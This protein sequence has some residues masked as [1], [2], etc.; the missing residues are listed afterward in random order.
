MAETRV[1]F[2]RFDGGEF[3]HIGPDQAPDGTYTG[4]NIM[5]YRNGMLGPRPGLKAV[6][7]T[8][9]GT[10]VAMWASEGAVD[11]DV[12]WVLS[13][14]AVQKFNLGTGAVTACGSAGAPGTKT[15]QAVYAGLGV[16]Y[17]TIQ[18]VGTYKVDVAAGTTTAVAGVAGGIDIAIV[19]ER[20]FVTNDGTD[21]FT[22]W[23]SNAGDFNTFDAAN[24]FDVGAK[25]GVAGI[26]GQRDH[27]AIVLQDG[28]WWVYRGVGS[29]A[30]LRKVT[31][32]NWHPWS[33]NPNAFEL[34]ANDEILL[35]CPQ[36]D[37]PLRFDGASLAEDFLAGPSGDV[38]PY[39]TSSG[40]K[41]FGARRHGEALA[42]FPPSDLMVVRRD[43]VYS[44]FTSTPAWVATGVDF[45]TGLYLLTDG[46]ALWALDMRTDRPAFTSDSWAR[47][48]DLS[49]TPVDAYFHLPAW[50]SQPGTEVRVRQVI[51]DFVKYQTG[52]TGDDCGFTLDLDIFGRYEVDGTAS[53]AVAP[54]LTSNDGTTSGVRSRKVFNVGDQG[55][56]AGFQVGLT[57]VRGVAVRA[58]TVVVDTQASRPTI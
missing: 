53:P 22:V 41:V 52:A 46:T 1:I 26:V 7:G 51:V 43:E 4:R 14:G 13:T 37:W 2:D 42:I 38:A 48:G 8:P 49:D 56:G 33:F 36:G 9:G 30:S 18:G 57:G 20:L 11:T 50:W 23:Y 10:I 47:P 32:D 5:R 21:Y 27:L 31:A 17:M 6:T 55:Y 45:G 44:L 16:F 28:S 25:A 39:S 35:W 15:P 19:G 12:W 34:L 3:G 54:A 40:I 24:F 58:I 29:N